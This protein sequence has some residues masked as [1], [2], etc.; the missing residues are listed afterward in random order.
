MSV[1]S[2][3]DSGNPAESWKSLRLANLVVDSDFSLSSAA[4]KGLSGSIGFSFALASTALIGATMDYTLACDIAPNG[5]TWGLASANII[6][7]ESGYYSI[8]ANII[9]NYQPTFPTADSTINLVLTNATDSYDLCSAEQII[10]ATDNNPFTLSLNRVVKLVTGK[11]Y[12]LVFL[13]DAPY[14]GTV[15]SGSFQNSYVSI[16]KLF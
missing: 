12:N 16:I 8:N 13:Q 3:L 9:G 15:A 1:N 4:V 14:N 2:L 11:N 6:V 5:I 10:A 7:A